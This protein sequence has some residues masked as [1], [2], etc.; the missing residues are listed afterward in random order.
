MSDAPDPVPI[1]PARESFLGRASIVWA[2]PFIALV[3][4]LMVAWQ[5]YNDRGPLISI[6]FENGAGIVAGSTEV[7]FRDVTVGVV[8]DVT[9]AEGLEGVVVQVRLEKEVAR[10]VDAGASFWVVRPELT[11]QGVSG[12][13]TVLS[14]IFIE[15]SWDSEIGPARFTFKG[16]EIP[17]LFRP[18]QEGL[19]IALRTTSGGALTD[20][21]PILFRGIEIGRVGPAR[22]SPQG[23]FAIAEAIIYEPHGRLVTRNSRFWDTSGFSVSI[24]PSGAEVDFS[25]LATLVGGGITF[26]TFVSGG[27]QVADGT[28]FEVF[29]DEATARNSV[30]NTSEA[31]LLELRV[32]FDENISG[33]AVGAPVELS[34]LRIGSVE[35]L[36]G[37]VD[38]E[39]FGDARVRLN[40]IIGIQPT[41]LGLSGD[42]EP[43]AA[44]TFLNARVQEGLRARLASA[45]LLTGGLKVELVEIEDAPAVGPI[46]QGDGP[47][48][49]PSTDSEI[50]DATA[51]V[52]GV[53]TRINSLPF[54]E[55][56]NSAI[57]FMQGAEAFISSDDL[58]QTPQE[59]RALLNDVRMIV[60]S[61]D[62]Q[63]IPASLNAAIL[64]A[65]TLLSQVEEGQAVDRVVEAISAA[66]EAANS[67]NASVAGIPELIDG[68]SGVAA[69]AEA[70]P[71]E[72]LTVQLT[73]L[74]ASAD[75][76]LGRP[77]AQDLPASLGAALDELNATLTELREGGA[78]RNVN[79]TLDSAREAADAVALSS[80]DLPQLVEQIADVFDQASRTIEGYNKG[81]VISRDAQAALRD[82]SKAANAL[83]ALAR[84]LE[85]NPT[86]LIR[87]R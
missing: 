48:T 85:R 10:F 65:E 16:L 58:R 81:D 29:V 24:G 15:G 20:N 62:V 11:V 50:S 61:Q 51:T 18:G 35:S 80:R 47:P 44:V 37:I 52:E 34:G 42:I 9:F 83:T 66:T 31:D 28:V 3:L 63:Q 1:D 49:I 22:I 38:R 45:S 53:F 79:A 4:A 17:P 32:I 19:Q 72:E 54:E 69:K 43:E 14:G 76:I 86:A 74:L 56:L 7:R 75:A 67:V 5:S 30:F 21:S 55:L 87:G 59:V 73:D 39:E 57:G 8:E 78:V 13:D 71:L 77:E 2:I 36:S 82:I 60:T 84:L 40:V 64:R 23:N 6:E 68:L 46:A 12:L 26:N 27:A 41:R 33:L 70:L 25:S